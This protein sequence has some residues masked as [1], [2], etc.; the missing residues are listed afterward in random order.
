MA[1]KF[2]CS[3]GSDGKFYF[4]L[5]AANGEIILS[6]QG[7]ADKGGRDNGIESV[8]K[9]GGDAGNFRKEVAKDGR[10]FFN[11]VA[12]NGQVIGKSQMYKTESGRDNGIES[13]GKNAAGASVVDE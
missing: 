7:Y 11:L 2:A 10:F 1:G 3:T 9:N 13:V 4:S 8:R 6:S 12:G 5:K